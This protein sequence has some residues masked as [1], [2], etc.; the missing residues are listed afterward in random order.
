MVIWSPY[1]QD[2]GQPPIHR[3]RQRQLAVRDQLEHDSCDERLRHAARPEAQVRLHGTAGTQV[4][5]AARDL[6]DATLVLDPRR[7]PGRSGR[8]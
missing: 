1:G 7:G 5:D 2:S 6:L 8:H 4:S 3:L